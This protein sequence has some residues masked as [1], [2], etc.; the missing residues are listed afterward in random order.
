[1]EYWDIN[2]LNDA[3]EAKRKAKEEMELLADSG[4]GS[5]SHDLVVVNNYTGATEY[6][7]KK[8]GITTAVLV[9][10]ESHKNLY[11]IF[12]GSYI[13]GNSFKWHADE[14]DIY[15][16]TKFD[17]S[18][19][20]RP[21]H[22]FTVEKGCITFRRC[23]NGS[24]DGGF[25]A[26]ENYQ[27]DYFEPCTKRLRPEHITA[28]V[29]CLSETNF[30]VWSTRKDVFERIGACGSCISNTFQCEFANGRSFTC[31]E[32][33]T[34]HNFKAITKLLEDICSSFSDE[35][36]DTVSEEEITVPEK[37]KSRFRFSLFK[38]QS[39]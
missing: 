28:L 24:R 9:C 8:C 22:R 38:K 7:C 27:K 10:S 5:D 32:A 37:K 3:N 34:C 2:K 25:Y 17:V 21:I 19:G 39:R 4:C 14:M 26:G 20:D 1:M 29:Q 16:I 15:N 23:I 13:N 30:S 36:D 35:D 33:L 6:K 11:S 31:Y 18:Y 12:Y